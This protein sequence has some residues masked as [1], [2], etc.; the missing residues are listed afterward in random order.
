MNLAEDVLYDSTHICTLCIGTCTV[1]LD[2]LHQ[3]IVATKVPTMFC[4]G[5]TSKSIYQETFTAVLYTQI[6]R[7][8]FGWLITNY[9]DQYILTCMSI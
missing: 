4:Q 8:F 1:Y 6:L 9:I 2:S 7:V 5:F 3:V